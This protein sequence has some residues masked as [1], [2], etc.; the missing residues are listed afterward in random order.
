VTESGQTGYLDGT[1][2]GPDLA[3]CEGMEVL[4]TFDEH[5]VPHS[6]TMLCSLL[7]HNLVSKIHLLYSCVSKNDIETLGTFIKGYGA[8]LIAYEMDAK[9]F[10]EFRV[11]KESPQSSAANYFRLL[12]PRLLPTHLNKVL[13][14]DS[15]VIV[16]RPIG[17][18]WKTNLSNY[19]LAAVEDSFW[20]PEL[21]Y[22]Q[23]PA[24]TK[25]FNSGVMLINLEYWR[26]H[27][28]GERAIEF[29]LENPDKVDYY[30]Q[31]ALNATLINRWVNV[32]ATWNDHALSA[33]PWPALRNRDVEDPAVVH[34]VGGDKPWYWSSK[35]PFKAEYRRYRL[36]TP[37][38]LYIEKRTLRVPPTI[39]HSV[40]RMVR[41]ALP[42]MALRR[43]R[44]LVNDYKTDVT[45]HS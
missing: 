20:C 36:K 42:I 35:H 28:V 37:W 2:R 33:L 10:T 41:L 1:S 43:L 17:D 15:D 14:L 7:E 30:D 44:R 38:W 26:K 40:R 23:M 13:Y 24:N 32:S 8:L 25:Y 4:C 34:F 11:D 39:S 45:G 29:A 9:Q 5:F 3:H 16:R 12:A 22:V 19:A 21:N 6:A 27:R 31:D 18:L